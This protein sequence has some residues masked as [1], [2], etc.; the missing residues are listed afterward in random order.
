M[1]TKSN[2]ATIRLLREER[3]LNCAQFADLVGIDRAFMWKIENDKMDGSPRTRLAI[4]E[5]LGVS[6]SAITYTVPLQRRARRVAA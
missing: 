3:G 2:G 5:A 4:A 1:P 6:V